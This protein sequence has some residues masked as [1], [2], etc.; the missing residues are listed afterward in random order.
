[1]KIVM[2]FTAL[3]ILSLSGIAQKTQAT[4]TT[5]SD[6]PFTVD[7]IKLRTTLKTFR[8]KKP[9]AKC[10]SLAGSE[11][12]RLS[13]TVIFAGVRASTVNFVFDNDSLTG[14][15]LFFVPAPPTEKIDRMMQRLKNE[16]GTPAKMNL[17]F[18]RGETGWEWSKSGSR[19]LL[20]PP[21]P[22]DNRL[23][24]DIDVE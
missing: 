3:L 20:N 11:I 18:P 8:A 17:L 19:M 4:P 14:I 12:C 15:T 6:K 21:S 7:G 2:V 23:G 10:T 5:T 22:S 24:I 9:A 13:G 1:M 16:Y